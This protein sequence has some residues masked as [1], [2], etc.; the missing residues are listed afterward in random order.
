MYQYTVYAKINN[1]EFK[2][3]TFGSEKEATD[4]V[5]ANRDKFRSMR[6]ERSLVVLL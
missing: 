2:I 6:I 4:L 3:K 1:R 5:K